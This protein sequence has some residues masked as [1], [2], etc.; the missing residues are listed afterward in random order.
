MKKLCTAAAILAIVCS[1][2]IMIAADFKPYPGA[3]LDAK[4]T[5]EG[6]EV[7]QKMD[8]KSIAT[9]YTTGDPFAKVAAFYKSIGTEYAMPRASGTTGQP[10]NRPGGELWEAYFILDGAADLA[11]SRSWVKVQRPAIGLYMEDMPDMKVRDVTVI[12]L[13]QKK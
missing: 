7:A 4:A 13:S 5:K 12:L 2:H 1:C 11:G 9:V 8:P 3:T 6:T 10:K